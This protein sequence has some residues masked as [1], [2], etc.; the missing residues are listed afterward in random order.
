MQ[1]SRI[2]QGAAAAREYFSTPIGM[3]GMVRSALMLEKLERYYP[4]RKPA[5]ST[6]IHN[7]IPAPLPNL[8]FTFGS[9]TVRPKRTQRLKTL[10]TDR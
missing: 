2:G 1:F 7:H 9:G 5:I 10:R 6:T 4:S 3:R 8:R